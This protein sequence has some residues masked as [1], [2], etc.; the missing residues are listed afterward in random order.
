MRQVDTEKLSQKR[1]W[2]IASATILKT[3]LHHEAELD[4]NTTL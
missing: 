4:I 3:N 2:D 1:I